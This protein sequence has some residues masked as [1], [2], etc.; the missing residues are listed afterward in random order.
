MKIFAQA[1]AILV[2][3]PVPVQRLVALEKKKLVLLA[4]IQLSKLRNNLSHSEQRE[5]KTLQKWHLIQQQPLLSEI[6]QNPP[7]VSYKRGRSLKTYS[8]EQNSKLA[9]TRG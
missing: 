8:F 9:K 4:E 1:T 6:S 3:M 5:L 2:P 7:T